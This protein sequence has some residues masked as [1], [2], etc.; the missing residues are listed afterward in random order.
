MLWIGDTVPM[1]PR[2]AV[3]DALTRAQVTNDAD[4]G[5]GFQLTFALGAS[6]PLDWDILDGSLDADEA[7]RDRR[8]TSASS[9]RS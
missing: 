8:S 7:G 9:R 4:S 6:N 3:M 1:P 2:P 5:D